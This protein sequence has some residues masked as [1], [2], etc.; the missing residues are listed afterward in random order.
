MHTVHGLQVATC[1]LQTSTPVMKVVSSIA[2]RVTLYSRDCG[3]EAVECY[4]KISRGILLQGV[5]VLQD[6]VPDKSI[7]R[8]VAT[9]IR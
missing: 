9:T 3:R 7:R 5:L 8:K 1:Q 6:Q 4:C 2:D